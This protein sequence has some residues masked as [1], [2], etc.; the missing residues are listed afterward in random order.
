MYL[1]LSPYEEKTLSP[2]TSLDENKRQPVVDPEGPQA[3]HQYVFSRPGWRPW[4]MCSASTG[5]RARIRSGVQ[6]RSGPGNPGTHNFKLSGSPPGYLLV[7]SETKPLE[8]SSRCWKTRILATSRE[9]DSGPTYPTSPC[10]L[11][12]YLL[13]R[14]STQITA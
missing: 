6:F 14:A 1:T 7:H 12:L 13:G 3:H 11:L 4:M 8:V 2:P 10:A 9:G 5:H